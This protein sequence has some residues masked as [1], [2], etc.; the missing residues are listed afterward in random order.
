MTRGERPIVGQS[1]SGNREEVDIH[2]GCRA[3]VHVCLRKVCEGGKV[4]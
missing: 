1:V 3:A 4:K 2:S